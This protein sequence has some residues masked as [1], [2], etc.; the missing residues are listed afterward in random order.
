LC[1][2]GVCGIVFF[3]ELCCGGYGLTFIFYLL[4]DELS[5]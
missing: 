3:R 1:L 5:L 2:G 4:I